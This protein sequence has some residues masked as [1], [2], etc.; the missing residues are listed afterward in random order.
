[1]TEQP[2]SP[3]PSQPPPDIRTGTRKPADSGSSGDTNPPDGVPSAVTSVWLTCQQPALLQRRGRYVPASRRHPAKMLPDLAVHAIATYSRPGD[4][5]LDPMCGAG[6]TLVEAVHLGRDAIGVDLE[7]EFTTLARANLHLAR[8]Q[9]AS[10]TGTVITA[11]ATRLLDVLPVGLLGKVSLVVTSPPYGSIT[12]GQVQMNINQGVSKA[13]HRYGPPGHGNLAYLGWDALL[14]GFT[15]I[16]SACREVL[17]PG[18]IV[19]ITTRPV[20]RRRDDL[21][22]F[23]S[24]AHAAAMSAGLE[25]LE[26]C[27]A[28]LAAA[29]QEQLITRAS[30]WALLAARR[31]RREGIPVSVVA[32]EDVL[33]LRKR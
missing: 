23:P 1:M 26:R 6:T 25:P 4:L 22:D 21:I 27:V 9:G 17:R 11:D 30:A 18:G 2:V 29:R 28:L 8:D 31:A 19:V 3:T 20:R 10:G 7:A 33:I 16:M 13:Y 24:R 12:H 14:S 32:H 5:V 15:A